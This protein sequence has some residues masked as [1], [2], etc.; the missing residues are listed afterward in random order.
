M[1]AKLTLRLD[2]TLILRAKDYA[3][4]QDRS[5]SQLVADYFAHLA[6]KPA[7][8]NKT[9]ARSAA[10]DVALGPITASLRGALGPA[11]GNAA[12]KAAKGRDI[13]RTHLEQKY[14]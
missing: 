13:Y 11:A 8:G 9:K 1:S 14:L 6:A 7:A 12:A 4:V 2:Q 10:R 5:V 3:R